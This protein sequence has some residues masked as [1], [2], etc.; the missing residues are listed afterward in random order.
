MLGDQH[1]GQS[2]Q[3][4]G[5]PQQPPN[6]QETQTIQK[7]RVQFHVVHDLP[8]PGLHGLLH[9][10]GNHV[11]AE[12]VLFQ[13]VGVLRNQLQALYHI[14]VVFELVILL[15]ESTRQAL[16][17]DTI[18]LCLGRN[19]QPSQGP[20]QRQCVVVGCLDHGVPHAFAD[21]VED[22]RSGLLFVLGVPLGIQFHIRLRH[23]N[24]RLEIDKDTRAKPVSLEIVQSDWDHGDRAPEKH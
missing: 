13:Q 11:V 24:G 4:R 8:T 18:D 17:C 7:A 5:N 14:R 23:V 1:V 12:P 22:P 2:Q 16:L 9:P 15:G 20:E 21:I 10:L 6:R 19:I 3:A